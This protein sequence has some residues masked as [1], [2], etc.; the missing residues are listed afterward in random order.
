MIRVGLICSGLILINAIVCQFL[1]AFLAGF[2]PGL[3]ED[4][5]AIQAAM[6]FGPILMIC[7]EFWLYD[8]R[9]DY[10]ARNKRNARSAASMEADDPAG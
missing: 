9:I 1:V 4:P 5:R 7:L 6:Y 8:R 3:F 10:L 2:L